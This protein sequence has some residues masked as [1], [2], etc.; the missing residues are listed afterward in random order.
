[1]ETPTA[2]MLFEVSWEVCNKVG[3][4][5]TVVTSKAA[6]MKQNYPSYFLIG[7]YFENKAKF[8]FEESTP[9]DDF[10]SIFEQLKQKG[11]VCHFGT[12]QI[13]GNPQ[14][15][16]INFSGLI[17][18][19]NEIKGNLWNSFQIDSLHSSWEF[20]EPVI[21][22][23]AVGYLL[24]A[25]TLAKRK[26]VVAHFHE[27]LA[28]AGLLYLKQQKIPVATVFTTH[29]TMLGRSIAGSGQDL[30]GMLDHMN[31]EEQAYRFGVQD[32][33]LLERACAREADIFTTVSEITALEAEKIIGRKP[34]VL[35]LNGLDIEKFP[36]VEELAIKHVT[37]R[38]KIKEFLTF[39]FF[40]YYT[41]EIDQTLI[42]FIVARNEFRNKG[43][44]V[45]VRSLEMLNEKLKAEGSTINVAAFFWIPQE[46]RGIKV[47]LLENKNFYRHIK[48]FIA[49]H[50]ENI[51]HNLM[52]DIMSHKDISRQTLLTED[53]LQEVKR[54][55]IHFQRKGNPPL[56][57][58]N[59]VNE[60][61]DE[62]LAAF[63]QHNLQNR[64]E[65]K[66]KIILYPVYLD[67][68]DG[69]IDLSY[70]DAMAGCHLGIFPS[71][72][73]PWGYTP[74]EAAAV[75]VP[76]IT[77]DLA[78]FGR[79][80]RQYQKRGMDEGIFVISR[81]GKGFDAA[82]EEMAGLMDAFVHRD[83]RQRNRNKLRAKELSGFADW[84]ELVDNYIRAH[85][86]AVGKC[87]ERCKR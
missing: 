36:T 69:L 76:S 37:C 18:K 34:E 40:P 56:V 83:K 38:E 52:Y 47:E 25:I 45:F 73:E 28:G 17:E 80:I 82:C 20:E 74:L 30:Y 1:M 58:H 79:F 31:P 5:Y 16:L 68:D 51:L 67:C 54:D 49:A 61:N 71:Y 78:G 11:I 26:K 57:T 87:S 43:I 62:I 4:I 27:W 22:S 24:E 55:L 32:K 81:Y 46:T 60:P 77:S 35:V 12:W 64:Q 65:D 23:V 9:P 53:F 48:S 85:N 6:L 44:D 8:E 14:A 3:G 84:N 75:G 86:L 2:E 7:P 10:Q 33:F 66:V 39:H 21:W 50:G 29:A 59:L 63:R 72:Y 70:Y 15:I 42:L 41:F 19:K 13:K